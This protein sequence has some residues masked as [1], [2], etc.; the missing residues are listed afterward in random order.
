MSRRTAGD[1]VSLSGIEQD[2]ELSRRRSRLETARGQLTALRAELRD[3][4]A[5]YKGLEAREVV[6]DDGS[7]AKSVT[8]QST[9]DLIAMKA[10]EEERLAAQIP[11]LEQALTETTQ[12]LRDEAAQTIKA[13]MLEPLRAVIAGL[14]QITP[15]YQEL[16]KL[17]HT[18][19]RLCGS[20]P[21]GHV[22]DAGIAQR[23]NVYRQTLRRL[24]AAERGKG[25][26]GA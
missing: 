23:L 6:A 14:E 7:W 19:Q 1:I 15:H 18:M 24:E 17:H 25:D 4:R 3:L 2:H 13:A 20:A 16:A 21:F 26:E 11:R 12:Q 10:A 22:V 8:L 9:E 5:K